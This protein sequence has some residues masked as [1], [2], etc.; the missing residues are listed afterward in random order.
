M[1]EPRAVVIGYGYA[2]RSFHSYLIQI[3]PGLELHGVSSRNS[4][5]RE[6]IVRERKCRAYEG[7]ESVIADPDVD[8][9]VLATPTSTHADM[10]I[11]A[12]G[13]GKHVVTDKPM[14]L[15]LE[16][17]DRMLAA[18]EETGLLLNV[19]Q[20]RRWD[21]DFL[22]VKGLI[23][24]AGQA[25]PG[26]GRLGD[27]RWIE[28][29]W[30]KFGAPGGWRGSRTSGGGR[31][32]DL[33]AHLLDQLLLLFQQA[34]DTV[35]CRMQYDFPDHDVESQALIVVGFADGVTGVC[36]VSSMSARSKP[37]FHVFG[38]KGT[39]LKHGLDPQEEALKAG[40]IDAAREDEA[41]FGHLQSATKETTVPTLPGRWRSY[42]ENIADVLA[43][44]AEP[45][46]KLAENRRVMA[47]MDAAL[48]SAR[49]NQVIR[50]SIPRT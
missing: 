21:G 42:Y 1:N 33:G 44:K 2:G 3:T 31:F 36:D 10:A 40:D 27:V 50:T 30:Q 9:V 17:C 34:I 19:F 6:R 8:L 23:D 37:R 35:Y 16:E 5:T 15:T 39:F 7:F 13:A 41:L 26:E 28:M 4:G 29:A 45:A 25:V 11:R 12:L 46:V 18:A 20:N 14:C 24:L 47:V 43:G 22:T 49:S 48:R 38:T 32:Y